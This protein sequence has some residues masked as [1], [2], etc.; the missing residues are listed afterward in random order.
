MGRSTT[1]VELEVV[2]HAEIMDFLAVFEIP[3][4]GRTASKRKPQGDI[5]L[6]K[7]G[8]KNTIYLWLTA[9]FMC[10]ATPLYSPLHSRCTSVQ[11]S[12]GRHS[13]TPMGSFEKLSN[14]FE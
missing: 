12:C 8:M 11:D 14:G 7:E 9:L 2:F 4:L 10:F 13:L 1:C 5:T 3:T 6:S